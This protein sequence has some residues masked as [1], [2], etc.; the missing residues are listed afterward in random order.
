MG[1][2]TAKGK[3]GVLGFNYDPSHFP[4]ALTHTILKA[5]QFCLPPPFIPKGG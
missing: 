5:L 1:S 2:P 4:P 3:C